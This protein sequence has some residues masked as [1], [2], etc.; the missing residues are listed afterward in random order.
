MTAS[1]RASLFAERKTCRSCWQASASALIC[2]ELP[3]SQAAPTTAAK[4][5]AASA[6]GWLN[7]KNRAR[8]AAAKIIKEHH[9]QW[10]AE[11]AFGSLYDLPVYVASL[12]SPDDASQVSSL[13]AQQQN[14]LLLQE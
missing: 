9:N 13:Q 12:S 5:C 1:A 2:S 4:R 10:L 14:Y 11:M 8:R 6:A 7:T 3:A